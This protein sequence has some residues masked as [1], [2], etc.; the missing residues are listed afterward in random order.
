MTWLMLI[1]FY[2]NDLYLGHEVIKFRNLYSCQLAGELLKDSFP[3]DKPKYV[4]FNNSHKAH[5]KDGQVQ[6]HESQEQV[7]KL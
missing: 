4:C 2:K 6:Q 1:M 5:K 7:G 3:E